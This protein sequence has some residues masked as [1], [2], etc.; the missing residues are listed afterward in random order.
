MPKGESKAQEP[1]VGS[2]EEGD[3]DDDDFME[4]VN[5][6]LNSPDGSSNDDK[7]LEGILRKSSSVMSKTVKFAD[8]D[9]V[10]DPK[11]D[12]SKSRQELLTKISRVTELLRQAEE[13]AVIEKD[14]RRK[15]EK[16]L[17]KLARELKKRNAQEISDK[18]RIEEV[19][20]CCAFLTGSS[21]KH[22]FVDLMSLSVAF[23]S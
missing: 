23:C 17:L 18:A 14:K 5:V 4:K 13:L 3:D 6:Y 15:K 11:S 20:H 7:A 8:E 21:T 22:P 1:L 2:W 19:G 10:D 16:N 9:D 12:A